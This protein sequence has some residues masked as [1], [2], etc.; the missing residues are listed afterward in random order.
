MG[1]RLGGGLGVAVGHTGS[2]AGSGVRNGVAVVFVGDAFNS[3]GL[4]NVGVLAWA[5]GTAVERLH[6]VTAIKMIPRL[7]HCQNFVVIV[8][9]FL[10]PV[11]RIS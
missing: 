9:I 10:R 1:V 5:G 2:K 6:P 4:V 11:N 8:F 7:I 3:T